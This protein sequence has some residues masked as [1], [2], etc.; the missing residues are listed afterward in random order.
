MVASAIILQFFNHLLLTFWFG[1]VIFSLWKLGGL[2][3]VLGE[4]VIENGIFSILDLEEVH[5]LSRNH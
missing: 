1:Q 5:L 4:E 3:C 2:L